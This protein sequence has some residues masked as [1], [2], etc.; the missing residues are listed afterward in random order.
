MYGHT[1]TCKGVLSLSFAITAMA[2][3][4][5]TMACD[6]TLVLPSPG[7]TAQAIEERFGAPSVITT[8]REEIERRVRALEE[9]AEGDVQKVTSVWRYL[10]H[11]RNTLYIALDRDLRVACA[12]HRGYF[13]VVE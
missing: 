9:C 7:S 12:G 3:C 10:K 5:G 2:A 6:Q 4:S 8:E 13:T 1:R 11:R